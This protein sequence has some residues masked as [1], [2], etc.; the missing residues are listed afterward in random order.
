M[1]PPAAFDEREDSRNGRCGCA[2]L[3]VLSLAVSGLLG[4]QHAADAEGEED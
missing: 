4:K 2:Y 1:R 3:F